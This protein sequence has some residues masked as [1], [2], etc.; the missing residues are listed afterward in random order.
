MFKAHLA[1]R[2]KQNNPNY[3]RSCMQNMIKFYHQQDTNYLV[4]DV[5]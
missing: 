5:E 4:Q 3:I 1:R 2:G